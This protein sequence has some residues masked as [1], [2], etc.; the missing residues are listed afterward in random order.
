MEGETSLLTISYSP[1]YLKYCYNDDLFNA[2][3]E[4]CSILL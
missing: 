1:V 2:P 4:L 3:I